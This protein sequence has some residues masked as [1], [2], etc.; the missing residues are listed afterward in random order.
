[1][2]ITKNAVMQ[3]LQN[4]GGCK[5]YPKFEGDLL[6]S[7]QKYEVDSEIRIVDDITIRT[8]TLILDKGVMKTISVNIDGSYDV[9]NI[10]PTPTGFIYASKGEVSKNFYIVI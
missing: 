4:M 9:F 6:V 5:L 1:M 7:V 3:K 8:D 2:V 10:K